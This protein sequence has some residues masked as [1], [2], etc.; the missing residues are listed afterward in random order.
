MKEQHQK[1]YKNLILACIIGV[2]ASSA[3]A[4]SKNTKLQKMGIIG[5][6]AS[7]VAGVGVSGTLPRDDEED[8]LRKEMD[9]QNKRKQAQQR[10]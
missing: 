2:L 4:Q 7:L 3:L 10:R 9:A 5:L 6:G 8:N 1:L